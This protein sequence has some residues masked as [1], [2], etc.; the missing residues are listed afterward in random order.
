MSGATFTV[1]FNDK[2]VKDVGV[3]LQNCEELLGDL[4]P[5]WDEF[6]P[7]VSAAVARNF[8]KQGNVNEQWPALDPAYAKLKA[9]RGYGGK[10]ILVCTG[11]LRDA[12]TTDGAPGNVVVMTP[13]SF[14][15]GVDTDIIPYARAHDQSG[16]HRSDGLVVRKYLI[17][18]V[19][20][21][22]DGFRRIVARFIKDAQGPGWAR[23]AR[24]GG[25]L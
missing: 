8:D 7:E 10:P 21:V 11:A 17:L 5:I 23:A 3:M 6:L 25:K 15:Y 12:A 14:F 13:A 2:S 18:D 20:A 22:M 24:A 4:T 9:K 16:I 1:Q 19:A